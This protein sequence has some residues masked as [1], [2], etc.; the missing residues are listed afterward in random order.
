MAW[1]IHCT[2]PFPMLAN[3]ETAT[4]LARADV[5][6]E[7]YFSGSTLDRLVPERAEA[8]AES[9]RAAGV[10]TA[11]FHAPFR[12]LSPGAQDEEVRR[13]TARRL[14]Q[15]VS[16]APPFRPL[17]IVMHGGFSNWLF[18]FDG[19]AWLAQAT[20]TFAEVA[21]AAE[22]AGVDIFLENVFDEKPDHLLRLHAA[23]GSARMG[24]CLDPGHAGLFSRLP[25]PAWVKAFGP[26]LREVHIHDNRGLRD[27]HL[28][29][30]EGRI[31]LPGVVRAAVDAGTPPVLTVEPHCEEHVDRAIA[32]LRALLAS[33]P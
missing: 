10:P 27:D 18:D 8:A 20:R 12:D 15:A 17:G 4:R 3:P 7:I 33:I 22:K 30:G 26:A 29:A 2:V 5:G 6:P 9:L 23:V 13:I 25:A 21:E 1:T 32:S 24:F 19:D 16:A 31:D 28:P 11:T 14:I